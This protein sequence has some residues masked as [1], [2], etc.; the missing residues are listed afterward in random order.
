MNPEHTPPP[1]GTRFVLSFG[2]LAGIAYA[3]MT[4]QYTPEQLGIASRVYY[5][6]ANA[7]LHAENFYRVH[8]PTNP[9]YRFLYPPIIV[10]LFVP[11]AYL[12][13]ATL[14]FALQLV[15]NSFAILGITFVIISGLQRRQ[16]HLATIDKVLLVGF[17]GISPYGV[18]QVI[19]GQV[20]LWLAFTI[21]LGLWSLETNNDM[22]AGILVALPAVV[23]LFPGSLGLYFL[24]SH[25]WRAIMAAVLTG[26]LALLLGIGVF[27]IDMTTQ[28]FLDVLP[29][30]LM[31]Q[32]VNSGPNPRHASVGLSRQLAAIIPGATAIH[33]GITLLF[34]VGM[35]GLLYRSFDTDSHRQS[36]LLGTL[37]ITLLVLPLDPLYFSLFLYPLCILLYTRISTRAHSFLLTG[38]LLTT[39]LIGY[40]TIDLALTTLPLPIL[41]ESLTRT[42]SA[43]TFSFI[44]PPTMGLYF[45]LASCLSIHRNSRNSNANT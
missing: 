36:T 35:I 8:P 3:I 29:H 42:I 17:V 2:I 44:L 30:R 28:Y 23:K 6:A 34:A 19:H 25:N 21:S 27:G 26:S 14:A 45:L 32:T 5:H 11:H 13:T 20:T 41:F 22:T 40:T 38:I 31:D 10:L 12:G 37:V 7:A 24:R 15:L 39:I 33:Y 9:G 4:I 18:T 16:I 1:I 43:T